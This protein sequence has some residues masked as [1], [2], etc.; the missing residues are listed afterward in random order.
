MTNSTLSS[1]YPTTSNTTLLSHGWPTGPYDCA[2]L[3]SHDADYGGG[4]GGLTLTH[5][6]TFILSDAGANFGTRAATPLVY[7]NFESGTPGNAIAGQAPLYRG[8]G[9]SWVWDEYHAGGSLVPV[10]SDTVVRSNSTRSSL[11]EF[12]LNATYTNS[13]EINHPMTATGDEAY[14]SFWLYYEKTSSGDTYTRNYK[15][16]DLFGSSGLTPAAYMG[17]GA[18]P[19][20]AGADPDLR[21]ALQDTGL[22]HTPDWNDTITVPSINGTWVRVEG[23]LKQS[24]SGAADG[25]YRMWLHRQATPSIEL[26]LEHAPAQTRATSDYWTQFIFG[27]YSATDT[28]NAT[29]RAFLDSIYFDSTQR[30]LEL[31]N[32]STWGACTRREVQPST[33]WSATSITAL[34]QKGALSAGNAWLYV[35]AADGTVSSGYP[36][37]LN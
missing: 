26:A 28:Y 10:Y 17:M 27:A 24:S 18:P 35:V 11:H 37:T 29:A 19:P 23:Y 22:S 21:S 30:R 7:D 5:G 32:A 20:Q 31:G 12:D 9:G 4:G 15:P 33:A 3:Q 1:H 8:I 36:V 13:L 25:T 6:S 16:W 14:F 2:V 34:C